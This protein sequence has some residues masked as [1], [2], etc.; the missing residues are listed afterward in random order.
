MRNSFFRYFIGGFFVFVSCNET[1]S[2]V[3]LTSVIRPVGV[4]PSAQNGYGDGSDQL[5]QPDDVE[6]LFDGSMVI[7]DVDNNR[8]QHFSSNGELLKSIVAKDLGLSN[9]NII[10]TGVAKDRDGFIYITLEGVGLVVRLTPNLM[11]DQLIGR[12]CDVVAEDYYR[13]ENDGCLIKPQGLVVAKNGDIYVVDMAK[14]NFKKSGMRNFGF[15]KFKQT[16]PAGVVSYVYDREFASTQ[17]VTKIMRKS[18]GMA[19]SPD[20]KTLYIAEEKPHKNQFGN[21][22]KFRYVAAFDLSSGKFYNKLFGITMDNDS[23]ID[24]VFNNSVEG[25][26]TFENYLF[27]VDEKGGKVAFFDI[28]SGDHLGFL[29]NRAY[30]Y[31]DDESDCIIDGINY[32][33]QTII[34]GGAMSHL[35]NDWHKNELASPDGIS[36]ISLNDGSKQLAVVDQWN[37]RILLYDLAEILKALD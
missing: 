20:Q 30:Y 26:S 35:K 27:A 10:P 24:G 13:P 5:A 11:F 29:G 32:N 37:S 6:I 7:T 31:C 17:E 4:I 28:N 8:I 34:A 9:K 12:P 18:E 25:I 15:R 33:E 36:A 16:K 21:K 23:I 14:K 19:I 1:Q 2:P 3:D 22:N